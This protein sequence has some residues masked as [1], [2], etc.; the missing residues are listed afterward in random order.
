[1]DRVGVLA[2]LWMLLLVVALRGLAALLIRSHNWS[3]LWL[4]ELSLPL[5]WLPLPVPAA[6]LLWLG[7]L[8]SVIWAALAAS[9]I[10]PVTS[11]RFRLTRRAMRIPVHRGGWMRE[12]PFSRDGRAIGSS[13]TR[14]GCGG[15]AG[16][17]DLSAR[18]MAIVC[19]AARGR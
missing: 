3:L 11:A 9:A 13:S 7:P 2:P 1:M 5:P 12:I 16:G 4:P 17:G 15:G 6:F 10:T 8:A 19:L 18:G 14:A